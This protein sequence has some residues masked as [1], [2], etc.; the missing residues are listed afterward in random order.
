MQWN[1]EANAGFTAGRPWLPIGADHDT[2]NVQAERHDPASMLSLY[3]QLITLRRGEPALEIGRFEPVEAEGDVLAYIRRGRAGES[4]FLIALNLGSRAQTLQRA[5]GAE[6][7]TIA[8]STCCDRQGEKVG[9]KIDLRP[10]EG[11][12]VRL[13]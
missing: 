8:L 11:V 12:V 4:A 2:V 9:T 6:K 3:A 5:S 1:A 7:G 13:N 10:D